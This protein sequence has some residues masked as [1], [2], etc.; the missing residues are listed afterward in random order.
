MV[1]SQNRIKTA[2]PSR[3]RRHPAS[4]S[5]KQ[6]VTNGSF[7]D[8]QIDDLRLL[9]GQQLRRV[10]HLAV[11]PIEIGQRHGVNFLGAAHAP[12]KIRS[13]KSKAGIIHQICTKSQV[14]GHTNC[15]FHGIVCAHAG[16]NEGVDSH[17]TQ[18]PFQIGA[19]EGAVRSLRNDCLACQRDDF[20][21]KIVPFLPRSVRRIR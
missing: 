11:F 1:L 18:R 20:I 17:G 10:H 13:R 21:L 7:R 9:A 6:P 16:Y 14:A 12:L 19:D 4:H 3:D 15:G 5:P 2:R 8:A